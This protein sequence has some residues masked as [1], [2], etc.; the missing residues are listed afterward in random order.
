M[1]H[2]RLHQSLTEC[3]V[4][5]WHFVCKGNYSSVNFNVHALSEHCIWHLRFRSN[6]NYKFVKPISHHDI[7]SLY[8]SRRLLL[9]I[10]FTRVECGKYR[11]NVLPMDDGA[12]A[13]IRTP[14]LVVFSHEV[15]PLDHSTSTYTI[16]KYQAS[17]STKNNRFSK[18]LVLYSS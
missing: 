11:L 13:G 7:S 12:A 5:K 14:H 15:S 9:W 6:I 16:F 8:A 3:Y 1:V 2:Q 17:Q 18:M 10:P 4:R